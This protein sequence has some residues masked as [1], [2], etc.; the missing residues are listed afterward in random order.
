MSTAT[1]TA[2][3]SSPADDGF[4]GVSFTRDSLEDP[5]E[6]AADCAFRIGDA[7]PSSPRPAGWVPCTFLW[8]ADAAAPTPIS[9]VDL[10]AARAQRLPARGGR[11]HRVLGAAQRPPAWHRERG[12]R[13]MLPVARD[14]GLPRG[15]RH[16]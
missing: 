10:A 8:I 12:L 6:F 15:P 5:T 4:G 13:L 2:S 14:L 11:A 1:A 3:S 9:R 7:R 16:L